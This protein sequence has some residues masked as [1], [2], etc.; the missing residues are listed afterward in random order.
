MKI[1]EN[2]TPEE[3]DLIDT[4]LMEQQ[5]PQQKTDFA[6]KMQADIEWENKIE[7]VRLLKTGISESALY[8]KLDDFHKEVMP[9]AKNTASV[10]NIKNTQQ[11]WLA[12]ASLIIIF[13]ISFF[14]FKNNKYENAYAKFYKPDPGL[15]TVMGIA[16]NYAFEE[17]MV[18]YK[19][20]KYN[21]A[22]ALWEKPLKEFPQNDTLLYF[23]A[24]AYQALNQKEKATT[25][26]LKILQQP[27]SDFYKDASWYQGLIYLE[28]KETEKAKILL[29]QSGKP[30]TEFLLKKIN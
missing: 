23:T 24:S 2:I 27:N 6:A 19:N 26:Y 25:N 3:L 7:T 10:K 13:I 30:E 11:I 8:K 16:N 12:A 4:F 5:S 22:I 14:L 1:A 15:I 21:N 17:G 29:I 9:L 28:Q 18:Q 20:E